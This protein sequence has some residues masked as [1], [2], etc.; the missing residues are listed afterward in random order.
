MPSTR[1]SDIEEVPGYEA[2]PCSDVTGSA[3]CPGGSTRE[4]ESDYYLGGYDI[5]SDYLPP[6]EEEFLSE[7]Q[8][9]PPLPTDE[10]FPEPYILMPAKPLVSKVST[11][12]SGSNGRQYAR[13]HFHPS[14]YLPPHNLPLGE[15]PHRD[16]STSVSGVY[17]GNGDTD[18]SVSVSLNMHPSVGASSASDMSAP[19]GLNDCEDGN[20]HGSMDELCQ[21]GTSFTDSQQQT[22]V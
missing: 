20:E 21:G 14:R 10:D 2:G 15:M 19:C 6:H 5:D 16:Y 22:E 4:L 7:D 1:L 3:P 8:L 9:P 11:L 17:A 18:N 13:P 12:S